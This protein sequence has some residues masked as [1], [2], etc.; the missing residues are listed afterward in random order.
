MGFGSIALLDALQR[1][2]RG[3]D[4][5]KH[6]AHFPARA[7]RVIFL[8]MHGGPSHVDTFDYKP[9][10]ERDSGKPLPFAGPRVVSFPRRG[11]NLIGLPFEFKQHGQSGAWVIAGNLKWKVRHL[12]MSTAAIRRQ[13]FATMTSL[14]CV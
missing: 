13:R 12:Q 11:G 5:S 2:T 6:V 9:L 1:E 3:G 8:F 14:R 7:K 10:L 4:A